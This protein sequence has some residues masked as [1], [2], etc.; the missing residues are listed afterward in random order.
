VFLVSGLSVRHGAHLGID[1]VT[2]LLSKEAQRAG[3]IVIYLVMMSFVLVIII[4]GLRVSLNNLGQYSPALQWRMGIV[5][6]CM[7]IGGA[8]MAIELV[9]VIR[10]TLRGE[11]LSPP[12]YAGATE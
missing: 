5:Y 1:V 10:R 12:I 4:Y 11:P 8:L 2:R 6:L 3:Q 9:G 7:P